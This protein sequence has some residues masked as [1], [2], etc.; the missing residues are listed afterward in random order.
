MQ[1]VPGAGNR[2]E[3]QSQ[4]QLTDANANVTFGVVTVPDQGVTANDLNQLNLLLNG[5][6]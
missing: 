2:E 1:M 4:D 3:T 6:Q 5:H